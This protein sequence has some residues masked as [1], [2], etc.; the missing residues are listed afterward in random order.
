METLMLCVVIVAVVTTLAARWPAIRPEEWYQ[1]ALNGVHSGVIGLICVW[2][3]YGR[4]RWSIRLA[5]AP[6]LI[7]LLPLTLVCLYWAGN[8][9]SYWFRVTGRP[10]DEY[11]LMAFRDIW[12][13]TMFW[14]SPIALGMAILCAWLFLM[15]RAG[16]F[17]PF[18]EPQTTPPIPQADR[19]MRLARLAAFV[20]FGITAIFPLILFYKLLTPTPLPAVQLPNPNGYDDFLAAGRMIGPAIRG[21]VRNWDQLTTSQQSAELEEHAAALNRLQQGLQKPCLN[22]FAFKPWTSE[23]SLALIRLY[24]ALSAQLEF[25]RRTNDLQLELETYKTLLKLSQEES[26]GTGLEFF[27]TV[28]VDYEPDAYSGIWNCASKLSVRECADLTKKLVDLDRNRE[29]WSERMERQR[30]IEE[31]SGWERHLN[32]ILVGWSGQQSFSWQTEMELRHV[33]QLRML[34]IKLALRAFELDYGRLPKSLSELVPDSLSAIPDDPFSELP[35]QYRIEDKREEGYILYS[36]GPDREDD[37]GKRLI[38]RDVDLTDEELF[39]P[40]ISPNASSQ[41]PQ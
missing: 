33:A 31:N 15:K 41:S 8:I 10:I 34:I 36:F 39:P 13:A 23:D 5:A 24:S 21:K 12:P 30:I 6:L 35:M 9:A 32:M 4:T 14:M 26:R 37:G 38:G 25:A 40:P 22:P 11:L 17:D 19:N 27:Q 16:W 2:F 1:F 29:P 20:L 7:F 3:V 28:F 18:R